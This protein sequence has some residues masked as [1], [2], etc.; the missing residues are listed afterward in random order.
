MFQQIHDC[1]DCYA[2]VSYT[3]CEPVHKV[4]NED[5]VVGFYEVQSEMLCKIHDEF[6]KMKICKESQCDHE[7]YD[8]DGD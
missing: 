4:Y 3:V 1:E 6:Q 5:V 7:V 2:R 8:G